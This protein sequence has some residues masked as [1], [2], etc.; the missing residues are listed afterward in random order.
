MWAGQSDQATTFVSETKRDRYEVS[1]VLR[2]VLVATC[3]ASFVE[4]G[5]GMSPAFG[6]HN[7]RPNVITELKRTSQHLVGRLATALGSLHW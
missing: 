6:G 1:N 2:E 5:M 7:A 4:Y 3:G